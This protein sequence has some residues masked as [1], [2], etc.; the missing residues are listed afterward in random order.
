MG[1]LRALREEATMRLANV[2]LWDPDRYLQ[3]LPHEAFALLRREAP[4]F[5]HPEPDGPGFWAV[6]RHADVVHVSR[7]PEIFSSSAGGTNIFDVPEAELVWIRSLLINMD[8]PQHHKFRRLI[9]RRFTPRRIHTLEARVRERAREIVDGF[10]AK[11]ECDFVTEVAAELPLQVIAELIGIRQD[12]RRR[13]F[14]LTNRLIGTTDPDFGGSP[15]DGRQ[16]AAEMWVFANELA[17]ARR[18]SPCEDLVSALVQADVDG[19]HLTE[20]EF[21]SFFLLLCV[22]GSETTRNL[23]SGGLLA[24]LEHPD[25]LERLRRDK[26]LLTRAIEELLRFVT[27]VIHFRRTALVDTEL[28]GER[29]R[30]G[31]K[32][33]LYYPSANRDEEV[34]EAPQRLDLTREKNPHLAFGIGQHFCLGANLARMEIATIFDELLRRAPELELAGSVRRLRSNFIHGI[35]SMPVR[36]RAEREL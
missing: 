19:E 34:F 15:D 18:E 7:N 12:E 13:I 36:V 9:Q 4:V 11:G 17:T 10:V 29:I 1:L 6:T 30:A 35:K 2:D 8:P 20:V 21:N 28:R 24:L 25:Q 5:R 23:I 33:V 31:D 26:S 32:V 22:A 16:A 14:D 3:G 27:P